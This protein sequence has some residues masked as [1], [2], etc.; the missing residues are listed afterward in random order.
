VV[1][2]GYVWTPHLLLLSSSPRFPNGLANK[3]GL[4]GKY[5]TGHRNVS[6]FVS[7]PLK[8]YPGLNEQHSLVSKQFMRR[9]RYDR[10]LRHDLRVWESAVDKGPR[11][12]NDAGE[13]MLGDAIMADWRARTQTGTA[14]VRCY[15]DVVPARERE[16]TLDSSASQCTRRPAAEALLA[17]RGRFPRE[18]RLD[19]GADQGAVRV[20]RPR[21][22]RTPPSH[23]QRQLPGS[24]R[25]WLPDGTRCFDGRG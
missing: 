8:L 12:R 4:V 17:R 16:L 13:L 21:R 20:A 9:P 5:L 11:L 25:G 1:G 15:Y 10:Y 18:S 24:P 7:L 6:G 2:G 3:S 14:R 23:G 19:R 22:Q